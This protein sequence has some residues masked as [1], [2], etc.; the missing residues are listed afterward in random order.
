MPSGEMRVLAGRVERSAGGAL[1][2]FVLTCVYTPD[3]VSD[4]A[5]SKPA[6]TPS[7]TGDLSPPIYKN[8]GTIN[9]QGG[10]KEG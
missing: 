2:L 3:L 5:V 8:S 6:V 7:S 4:Q 9:V 10:G 1:E